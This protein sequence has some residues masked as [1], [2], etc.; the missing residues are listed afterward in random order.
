MST[1]KQYATLDDHYRTMFGLDAAG[2]KEEDLTSGHHTTRPLSWHPSSSQFSGPT[3]RLPT[4]SP[5]QSQTNISQYTPSKNTLAMPESYEYAHLPQSEAL[6]PYNDHQPLHIDVAWSSFMHGQAATECRPPSYSSLSY[7]PTS[8]FSSDVSEF[9][10][11]APQY[12]PPQPRQD[13]LPTQ[14]QP[15]VEDHQGY[16]E[17]T[18]G[19]V[20]K[21]SDELIGL[22]LYDPPE[23]SP[24][25]FGLASLGK[26]LKLEETWQPP[27]E[28]EEDEDDGEESSDEEEEPTTQLERQ[29]PQMSLPLM[30]MSGQSFFFED[31]DGVANKW[32]Y[33]QSKQPAP[34]P[35]DGGISYGWF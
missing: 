7:Q 12:H 4:K 26:G 9:N 18:H 28:M 16:D 27:E 11:Q 1:V 3:S 5:L 20:R 34:T 15:S 35:Q 6:P 19:L 31:E 14:Q 32:W 23:S 33:Q 24:P 10:G 2:N 29:W 30:N 8:W 22:G 17:S 21:K 25:P 13:F